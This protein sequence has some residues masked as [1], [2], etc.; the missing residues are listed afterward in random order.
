LGFLG[1]AAVLTAVIS[2]ALVW[3]YEHSAAVEGRITLPGAQ[4]P[5]HLTGPPDGADHRTVADGVSLRAAD[6]PSWW[7]SE[8][9]GIEIEDTTGQKSRL[10]SCLG[11]SIGGTGV[12]T[13][14]TPGGLASALSSAPAVHSSDW[15]SASTGAGAPRYI[16]WSRVVT[17]GSA[18]TERSDLA[19]Y[20]SRALAPC[21]TRWMLAPPVS[22]TSAPSITTYPA[23]VVPG[24]QAI[25]FHVNFQ[26]GGHGSETFQ[27][28][29]DQIFMG[30]G[31]IEA[32]VLDGCTVLLGAPEPPCPSPTAEHSAVEKIMHRMAASAA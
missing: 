21:L 9:Y 26:V 17:V 25:A 19:R 2:V 5:S 12:L 20:S 7:K 23:P 11:S 24:V 16:Y 32:S 22:N 31:R 15:F 18:S 30:S 13:G 29:E 6:F 1:G 10:A 3:R 8:P 4:A 27:F 14:L 28:Y